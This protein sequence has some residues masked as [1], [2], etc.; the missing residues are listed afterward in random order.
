[1]KRNLLL[2]V[3]DEETIR[4]GLMAALEDLGLER[5][6]RPAVRRRWNG[7]RPPTL[8]WCCSAAS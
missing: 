5:S 7:L 6:S 2:I 8:I 1:M 4:D 3:D